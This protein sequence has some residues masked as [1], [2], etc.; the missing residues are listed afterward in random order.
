[1][2]HRPLHINFTKLLNATVEGFTTT[3]CSSTPKLSN[4][5]CDF[6]VFQDED[7][8]LFEAS[9]GSHNKKLEKS[10]K[11]VEV[12]IVGTLLKAQFH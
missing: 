2:V 1:M 12:D 11:G 6:P 5:L 9:S 10:Q 3:S 4:P 7:L 8:Q